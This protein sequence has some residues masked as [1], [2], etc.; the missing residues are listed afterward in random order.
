MKKKIVSLLSAFTV[1]VSAGATAAAESTVLEPANEGMVQVG[2]YQCFV[3]DG[4]YYT[5]HDGEKCLVINT[6]DFVPADAETSNLLNRAANEEIS[7]VDSPYSGTVDISN[8]D[9]T[10]PI[11]VGREA[12]DA[13]GFQIYA[14]F[15][16]NNRYNVTVY[17]YNGITNR[18]DENEHDWLFN[19]AAQRKAFVTGT[20]AQNYTKAYVIFHKDGSTG[21]ST[22]GYTI[23]EI[24]G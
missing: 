18:W 19:I 16:L 15:V 4:Q 5:Y 20:N 7:I 24:T 8:G 3:E 21:E 12:G 1:L 9:A 11:F 22:I 6:D 2:D 13:R 23:S 10:T 17:L 14:G